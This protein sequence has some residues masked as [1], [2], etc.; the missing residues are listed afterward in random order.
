MWQAGLLLTFVLIIFSLGK[1]PVFRVDRAGAAII[2]AALMVDFGVLTFDQAIASID[3]RTIVILF[4]MMIVLANLKVAGFFELIGSYV[5]RNVATKKG[6]LL[7]VIFS[8]GILS[9]L[10]IN[11]I[12]CLLFTPIVL[13]VCRQTRCNPIPYLLGVAIASNVGSA[14]TFLGNPQ[15]ILIASLSGVS[16]TSYFFTALPISFIGLFI[17]YFV[18]AYF[19]DQDLRGNVQKVEPSK[20]F[21][22]KYIVI[23]SL[24][25][26][27]FVILVYIAGKDLAITSSLGAALLLVTRRVQPNKIYTSIDF[28][29]LVIFVGLFII[30]GGVKHSGLMDLLVQQTTN[31]IDLQNKTVFALFTIG[32]SN[33]VSNVPAVML[34][35]FFLPSTETVMWWK[36][37]AL[38]STFAGNLTITGSIANLIVVEIAK[39]QNIHIGFWDYLKVGLPT[40]LITSLL[41][42]FILNYV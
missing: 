39:R 3:F 26:L 37:L 23:K 9:A 40:T 8:S 35:K 17:S 22:H 5:L 13:L 32:L 20:V 27:V 29:L 36:A 14:A 25:V 7:A 42:L 33:I 12:V 38:F 10:C 6:L 18:I 16:F 2:A 24:V 34:L 21:F 1:S 11:D 15:N 41:G 19:Y 4:F 30:I 28:N 31:F